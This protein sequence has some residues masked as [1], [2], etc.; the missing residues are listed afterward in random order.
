MQWCQNFRR[1]TKVGEAPRS[2][3][4]VARAKRVIIIIIHRPEGIRG[5]SSVTGIKRAKPWGEAL[6]SWRLVEECSHHIKCG[7]ARRKRHCSIFLPGDPLREPCK[8][9]LLNE[10]ARD[11][12]WGCSPGRLASPLHTTRQRRSQERKTGTHEQQIENNLFTRGSFDDKIGHTPT[13]GCS[14]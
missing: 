10:K 9:P 1:T 14:N 11:R 7:P 13:I 5:G 6:P 8:T 12:S 2:T 4:K 3:P